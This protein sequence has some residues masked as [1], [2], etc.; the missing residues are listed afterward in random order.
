MDY[1]LYFKAE[2]EGIKGADRLQNKVSFAFSMLNSIMDI[3]SREISLL[4]A[5]IAYSRRTMQLSF[6]AM[7]WLTSLL[8]LFE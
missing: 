8:F 5:R 6:S 1:C 4:T 3:K 7:A 2:E